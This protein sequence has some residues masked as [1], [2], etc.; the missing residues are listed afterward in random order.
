MRRAAALW[1]TLLAPACSDTLGGGGGGGDGSS[2]LPIRSDGDAPEL[3]FCRTRTESSSD[4]QIRWATGRGLGETRV[5][6]RTGIERDVR[7]HPDGNR[8][9]YTREPQPGRPESREVYTGS[10]DA[11]VPLLRLT[12][13]GQRDDAPTWSPDG[14]RIAFVSERLGQ[15]PRLFVADEDGSNALPLYDDGSD[16]E[17]PD[18]SRTLDRIAF[19]RG[20]TGTGP[21]AIWIVDADGRVAAPV[22]DGGAGIGDRHPSFLPDGSGVLFVRELEPGVARIARVALASGE[23]TF[24]TDAVGDCA[25][26]RAS[27]TADQIVFAASRPAA[28]IDGLR[29]FTMR[30]DGS[31]ESVL[32]GDLR[33]EFVG[34]DFL[35]AALP[36]PSDPT[37]SVL[38][39][40]TT[41]SVRNGLGRIARG[42]TDQLLAAD[43]AVLGLLTAASGSRE[44]AGL[45]LEI[46]LPVDTARDVQALEVR[47]VATLSEPS[48]DAVVRVALA[49][50]EASRN[51]T[52][53]ERRPTGSNLMDLTFRTTNLQHVSED[54]RVRIAVV[55]E[56]GFEQPTE[57]WIDAVF[58]SAVRPAAPAE[59]RT[60]R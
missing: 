3:L 43:E 12:V 33:Y 57:L 2:G 58:V 11:T 36:L 46:P 28:G 55:G 9:A 8:F 29:L 10:L 25:Q 24:L 34:V 27:P 18:W 53:L 59:G 47:V 41:S 26:P 54:A 19:S 52:I 23:I 35:P 14:S 40:L 37:E 20:M 5:L 1:I 51:D 56:N 30:S 48:P 21:K 49:N 6:D 7:I 38:A 16:Q 13:N 50:F 44:V 42:S 39:D 32:F 60:D 45:E 31:E 15:G 22:T 17:H 4:S